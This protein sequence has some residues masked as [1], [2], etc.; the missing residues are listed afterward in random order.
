V[1]IVA[2]GRAIDKFL[3]VVGTAGQVGILFAITGTVII[4]FVAITITV[5]VYVLPIVE[6]L[7]YTA[8][9]LCLAVG[10]AVFVLGLLY[11]G[12][13]LFKKWAGPGAF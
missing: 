10:F 13:K 11:E 12:W 4:I 6:V 9:Q 1:R 8:I 7:A 5:I 2:V 3:T